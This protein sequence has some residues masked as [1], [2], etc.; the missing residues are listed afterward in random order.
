MTAP[1][2]G[3]APCGR[4]HLPR[5]PFEVRLIRADESADGRG[6]DAGAVPAGLRV[7][8]REGR[9]KLATEF[10]Y[11]AVPH[12]LSIYAVLL[13]RPTALPYGSVGTGSRACG[14][15]SRSTAS[16]D[17]LSRLAARENGAAGGSPGATAVTTTTMSSCTV[18]RRDD[19]RGSALD[20]AAEL[21][22]AAPRRRRR[23]ADRRRR[24]LARTP[25]ACSPRQEA[26]PRHR[27]AADL[28]SA[29]LV[30]HHVD[31][32][33]AAQ[34]TTIVEVEHPEVAETRP[35]PSDQSAR[36]ASRADVSR[37]RSPCRGRD[38][39]PLRRAVERSTG[40]TSTAVVGHPV[41]HRQTKSTSKR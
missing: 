39:T 27:L 38:L 36:R 22:P 9:V 32:L 24:R 1:R 5:H 41:W 4:A 17:D 26:G 35:S 40:F 30:R 18:D 16:F 19:G 33:E 7:A 2:S 21:R 8:V 12:D 34:V 28:D 3:R 11:E 25:I 14:P 6:G 31:I 10:R 37:S 15:R 23:A 13:D 29:L 20:C